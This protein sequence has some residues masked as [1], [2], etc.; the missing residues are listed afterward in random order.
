MT[1]SHRAN[2]PAAPYSAQSPDSDSKLEGVT[3]AIH[4]AARRARQVAEQTGTF[5]IVARRGEIV[6]VPP[7]KNK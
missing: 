4:R 5:L 7:S 6:R 1:T 2:E 3:N